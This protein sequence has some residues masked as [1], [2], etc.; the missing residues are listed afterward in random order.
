M[1]ECWHYLQGDG[2][3]VD[4]V[5]MMRMMII[6]TIM[7]MIMTMMMTMMAMMALL[8]LMTLLAGRWWWRWWRVSI[9]RR[10]INNLADISDK[11]IPAK[12]RDRKNG[13]HS[14]NMEVFRW[15]RKKRRNLHGW[16]KQI[17][18]KMQ[19]NMSHLIKKSNLVSLYSSLYFGR[20]CIISIIWVLI[21]THIC[22]YI[23]NCP[24]LGV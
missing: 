16:L 4:T 2:A 18:P 6:M 11:A 13:H 14:N 10:L 1:A 19:Q 7:K 9:A 21:Y 17:A 20:F 5:M 8:T 12:R 3:D 23:L 24:T 15:R 22:V